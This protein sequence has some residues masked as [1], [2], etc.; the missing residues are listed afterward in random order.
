MPGWCADG[1]HM[2]N[3]VKQHAY[4]QFA[5]CHRLSCWVVPVRLLL[6]IVHLH[7]T[8]YVLLTWPMPLSLLTKI[9]FKGEVVEYANHTAGNTF[10]AYGMN[11]QPFEV[12]CSVASAQA[13]TLPADLRRCSCHVGLLQDNITRQNILLVMRL[14]ILRVSW[15]QWQ[16]YKYKRAFR[17]SCC[18]CSE[19]GEACCTV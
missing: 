9:F 2:Q 14:Y 18:A 19:E 12:Q 16:A 17:C 1:A 8:V 3:R 6:S 4:S 11:N 13:D 10:D 7:Q 15:L 5:E